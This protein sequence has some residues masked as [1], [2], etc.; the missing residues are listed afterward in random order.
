MDW[1]KVF[2][3]PKLLLKFRLASIDAIDTVP[4][5]D[6]AGCLHSDGHLL[7]AG[8]R[9]LQALHQTL[10]G[11]KP[12]KIGIGLLYCCVAYVAVYISK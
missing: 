2:C 12:R 3:F 9:S 11:Y 1:D 7:Q 6:A 8:H 5:S 4:I 10:H